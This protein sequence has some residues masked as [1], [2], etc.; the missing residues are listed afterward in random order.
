MT[1][2]KDPQP[3]EE[4]IKL[5]KHLVESPKDEAGSRCFPG[6]CWNRDYSSPEIN[7]NSAGI[8]LDL[9]E[10][11]IESERIDIG[12]RSDSYDKTRRLRNAVL[13]LLPKISRASE[14]SVWH[15]TAEKE[16][17]YLASIQTVIPAPMDLSL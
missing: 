6:N 11:I 2:K 9:T 3:V 8:N 16:R 5:L 1:D 10:L 4:T 12:I 14:Y 13:R 7:V 15:K 17:L